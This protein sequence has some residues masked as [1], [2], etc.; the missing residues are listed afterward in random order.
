MLDFEESRQGW[1]DICYP[2]YNNE[3]DK[4]WHNKLAFYEVG[5]GDYF[6]I[7]LEKENYGKIVY[8]SHDGGDAHGHYIA[9]NL[10]IY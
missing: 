8:L 4:V 7:E 5:N 6:A 3:Y 1:V 10:K 2:D 9:D